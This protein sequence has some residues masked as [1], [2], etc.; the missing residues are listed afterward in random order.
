MLITYLT[1]RL[2]LVPLRPLIRDLAMSVVLEVEKA[3]P[4]TTIIYAHIHSESVDIT[5]PLC[6][7]LVELDIALLTTDPHNVDQYL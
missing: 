4:L 3:L 7:V 1:F 5:C 6:R 2:A